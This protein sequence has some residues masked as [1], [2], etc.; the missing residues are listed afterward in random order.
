[1]NYSS[2]NAGA[3]FLI[4]QQGRKYVSNLQ[5]WTHQVKVTPKTMDALRLAAQPPHPGN[6]IA[7]MR[8]MWA[9]ERNRA[10]RQVEQHLERLVE[11]VKP[12]DPQLVMFMRLAQGHWP[13]VYHLLDIKRQENTRPKTQPK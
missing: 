12:D 6:L 11:Q 9:T 13:K 7:V 4:Q 3:N 1:M 5:S 8:H 10:Y 2:Q